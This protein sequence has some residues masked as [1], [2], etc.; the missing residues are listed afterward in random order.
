[1]KILIREG[2]AARNFEA[3]AALLHDHWENMMFCS[4]DKHPDSLVKGHINQLCARAVAKNIDIFKILT[5]ACL[6]PISHYR[7]ACGQLRPG[8]PADFI[9]L[10]DLNRFEVQTWLQ[11][12][13]VAEKGSSLLDYIPTSSKPNRFNASGQPADF[14]FLHFLRKNLPIPTR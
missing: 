10:K 9:L 7:L 5:A 6:N 11:G 2:S 3:L 8:D 14:V 12:R 1:M 4:D 13:L